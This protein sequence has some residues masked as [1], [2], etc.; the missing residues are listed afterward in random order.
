MLLMQRPATRSRRSRTTPQRR[1]DGFKVV[2]CEIEAVPLGKGAMNLARLR[3]KAQLATGVFVLLALNPICAPRSVFAGCNQLAISQ[4]DSFSRLN[5]IDELIV[6]VAPTSHVQSPLDRREPRNESRCSG[7]GCTDRDPLPASTT[8]RGSY[9]AS[10]LGLLVA[11]VIPLAVS[12]RVRTLN[13]PADSLA[14]EASTVFHPP[15]V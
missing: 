3:P 6:S 1:S 4:S 7:M 13:E 9:G 15:R 2:S 10:E 5:R 8:S 12:P 11:V 14:G